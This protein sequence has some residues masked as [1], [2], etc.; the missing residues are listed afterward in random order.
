[1]RPRIWT[2]FIRQAVRNILNSIMVHAISIGTISIAL[3]FLGAFLFFFI[4]LNNWMVSWGQSLSMSVYL[5]DG[6]SG[7]NKKNIE[8]ILQKIED[9]EIT[10]FVSKDMA[11][12]ELVSAL[13]EQAGLL[14]ALK[15]NPLPAS[16]E[17]IFK[18]VRKNPINPGSIKERLEKIDGIEEVLYSEQWIERFE[19]MIY[20]IKVAGIIV[21]CLLCVAVLF[22][23]TNT[24]K[25]MIYARQDEIEIYKLVGASDGFVKIPFL[26]EGGIQGLI[27]GVVAI[28][29]LYLVYLIFSLKTI[30]LFGLPVIEVMFL[31][32]SYILFLIVLSILLGLAGSFVAIGRFFKV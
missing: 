24:I 23:I 22:I 2:Y 30:N 7:K 11:K 6:L 8:S 21:G 10:G 32:N 9:A 20:I 4:N 12:K 18:D 19:G 17:L 5:E 26:L 25:L 31:P 28:L 13:G 3:L 1:M 16:Y 27:G 14:D 29:F 15:E